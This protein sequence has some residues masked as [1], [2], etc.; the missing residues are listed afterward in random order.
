MTK[1]QSHLTNP[2]LRRGKRIANLIEKYVKT[3]EILIQFRRDCEN[4]EWAT[5]LRRK[6]FGAL[7]KIHK[8]LVQVE[9][10]AHNN[11]AKL[12]LE[13]INK[14]TWVED[15]VVLLRSDVDEIVKEIKEQGE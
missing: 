8:I 15:K 5:G 7:S 14:Y 12:L 3:E 13:K 4:Y 9:K 11:D 2:N 1:T 6:F 10:E